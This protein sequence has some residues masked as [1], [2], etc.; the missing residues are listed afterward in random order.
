MFSIGI[1]QNLKKNKIIEYLP[2]EIHKGKEIYLE[3]YVLKPGTSNL[4]RKRIKL[5][6]IKNKLNTTDFNRYCNTLKKNL[7]SKLESGWNPF[8]ENEAPKAFTELFVALDNFLDS[9]QREITH[10]SYR[11]YR[12]FITMLK[13]W[14]KKNYN[15]KIYCYVFN[16]N[17]ARDYLN[18]CWLVKKIEGKTYNSYLRAYASIFNWL[19]E[20]GYLDENVFLGF[21]RKK[22]KQKIRVE[23][24]QEIREKI[25]KYCK[26]YDEQAFWLMCEL[27]FYCLIR[28]VEICR[29]QTKNVILDKQIIILEANETKNN[30]ER[31]SSIPFHLIPLLKEQLERSPGPYLFSSGS[32]KWHPGKKQIDSREIARKWSKLRPILNIPKNIQFY[33]QRDSGIIFLLDQGINPEYVRSQ[34]DHYSLEMTTRY[35]K[36]FRPLGIEEIKK[37]SI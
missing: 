28:P 1:P 35:T 13:C 8:I 33:S 11:T 7:N 19:V 15:E 3:Y 14:I 31:V 24:S 9:K 23:I 6:K 16:K 29:I 4:F 26:K 27:C 5:N 22:E 36:H 17:M 25:H 20:F 2:P 30:K 34:A 12:S 32:Q 18:Y 10:N 21:T 37:I